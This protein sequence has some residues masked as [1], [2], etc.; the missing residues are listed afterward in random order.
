VNLTRFPLFFPGKRTFFLEGADIFDFGL[1]LS[2][3][4]IPFFSRRIGLV[5]PASCLCHGGAV[6]RVRASVCRRSSSLPHPGG[7]PRRG[8]SFPRLATGVDQAATSFP[9]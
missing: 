2:E 6:L 5:F 3:D 1:G 7:V 8:G 4:L 9:P